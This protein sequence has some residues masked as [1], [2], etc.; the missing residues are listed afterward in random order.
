M[1][2]SSW[3]TKHNVSPDAL[4][5]LN[6]LFGVYDEPAINTNVTQ[7]S[8][9]ANDSIVRLDASS[10]G[11]RLW[12]NNKGAGYMQD[13]RF[14]RWGL[15]N[16]SKA[17]SDNIK[18]SDRIGIRSIKIE[19]HHVGHVIGQFVAREIKPSNWVYKGT[20]HERAQLK[21]LEL[22]MKMGGDACFATG[23]GTF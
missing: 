9:A 22:I 1:N 5:E 7:Y 23:K 14:I 18:S 21:F 6:A 20:P 4:Q 2:L 19:Q 12:R 11:V 10:V 8:E 3:A 16:D 13:G 15:L 17:L